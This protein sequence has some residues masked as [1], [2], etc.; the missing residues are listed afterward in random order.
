MLAD[1]RLTRVELFGG[2]GKASVPVD[3][4][5]YFQMSSFYFN[6]PF[7][8]LFQ[9]MPGHVIRISYRIYSDV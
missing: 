6:S 7:L 2:L 5:E 3:G 1:G 9:E 8:K 4:N